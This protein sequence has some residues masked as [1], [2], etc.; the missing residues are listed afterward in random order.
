MDSILQK[1]AKGTV[2]F[3]GALGTQLISSGLKTGECP[4]RWNL[5][6]PDQL[7]KIQ[8]A[9][10]A[11]GADVIVTNTFGANR[12]RLEGYGLSDRLGEINAAAARI[13]REAAD[14]RC[15]IAGD[16]GPTGSM[17]PP[18]GKADQ[19]T[20]EDIFAEQVQALDKAGVDLFLIETQVDLREAVAAVRAAKKSSELP[21]G[22][23]MTFNETPRGYFTMVGDT[24]QACCA[25]LAEAGA[26]FVG[27]NC[28]LVPGHMTALA[29]LLCSTSDLPVLIQ[30]NAGQ[31]EIQGTT[32]TYRTTPEQF[33][34][35]IGTILET[36][37]RAVGGCCGT[38]PD[39]I[40]AVRRLL[41]TTRT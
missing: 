38:V 2:L 29:E 31:P 16:L 10:V 39:T 13:A 24:V 6:H 35:G 11:A 21:V 19:A 22:I 7:K 27:A 25:E 30:P 3:D 18:M 34:E 9:Y 40:R 23:T 37:V 5:D 12:G 32:I 8:Q 36:G 33:A 17:F 1:L 15:L 20:L 28:S 4:E 26:D 14:G 41:D